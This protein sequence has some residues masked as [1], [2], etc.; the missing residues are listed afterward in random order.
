MRKSYRNSK[1]TFKTYAAAFGIGCV[2]SAIIGLFEGFFG[3]KSK[4]KK[5]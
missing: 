5:R 1:P 4:K 3:Y 2:I